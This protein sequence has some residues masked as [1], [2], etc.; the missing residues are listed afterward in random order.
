MNNLEFWCSTIARRWVEVPGAAAQ[1][2][3]LGVDPNEWPESKAK[4][5]LIGFI[6]TKKTQ[7]E[8]A[9]KADFLE[10]AISLPICDLPEDGDIFRVKYERTLN[11]ARYSNLGRR[12]VENPNMG[13]ELISNFQNQKKSNVEIVSFVS[14]ID[15]IARKNA[16]GIISKSNVIILQGWEKL[17][18]GIG[19]FGID[20]VSMVV[21]GTG[22]GKT[23]LAINLARA[24]RLSGMPVLFFNMEMSI[25]DIGARVI[26]SE[27]SI[28]HNDWLDGAIDY[29]KLLQMEGEWREGQEFLLTTGKALTLTQICSAI[30]ATSDP[31]K[32][33]F[34]VVD[35]DQKIVTESKD[36]EWKTLHRAIEEL[37]QIAKHTSSRIMVLAQGNDDGDPKASKRMK[38]V[39]ATVLHFSK[40]EIGF[41]IKAIKNRFGEH[42]FTIS[43]KYLPAKA[44][45][46]E[47]DVIKKQDTSE[48]GPKYQFKP[49][50][51]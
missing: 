40:T 21:S 25:Q 46:A 20:R 7:G 4:S 15:K 9:A 23:T 34:I 31:N 26:E 17:S 11:Q 29:Q 50:G 5:I 3:F 44:F 33:R 42:D 12:L 18:R 1:F 14:Q 51:F 19:G 27:L 47:G 28:D 16:E 41:Q 39:A 38:Q 2:E 45:A 10:R 49:R 24:A 48:A 8:F 35:Y 30:V 32:K 43:V 6:Q 36:D 13:H 22:I 37:E